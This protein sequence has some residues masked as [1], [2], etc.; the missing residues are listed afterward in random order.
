MKPLATPMVTFLIN[1]CHSFVFPSAGCRVIW[2]PHL[3][4][5]PCSSSPTPF[6]S[7]NS[8][9]GFLQKLKKEKFT[10]KVCGVFAWWNCWNIGQLQFEFKTGS[11][12]DGLL[13]L[14]AHSCQ[15]CPLPLGTFLV[16]QQARRSAN[17]RWC[18]HLPVAA[19]RPF[20][21]KNIPALWSWPVAR[22]RSIARTGEVWTRSTPTNKSPHPAWAPVWSMP[23]VCSPNVRRRVCICTECI[24]GWWAGV[25]FWQRSRLCLRQNG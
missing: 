2:N 15:S 16:H 22:V 21:H 11:K 25:G 6:V 13:W 1:F 20:H 14:L 23:C 10:A 24:N 8:L 4:K 5:W 7:W 18:W 17:P 3:S 9:S 19:L 12:P